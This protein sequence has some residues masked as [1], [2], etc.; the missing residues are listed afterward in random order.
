MQEVIAQILKETL[1]AATAAGELPAVEVEP[2]VT[3]P[4]DKAHG[5]FA[6]NVAMVAAK[7]AGKPPRE[8]ATALAAR[9]GANPMF[10]K[11]EIAGPGFINFYV[12]PAYWPR[13]LK[14]LALLGDDLTKV[15]PEKP[16]KMMVEFVSANP[17]GPL[18]VGHGRGAAVGDSL[19]RLLRAAGHHVDAE[20]YIND[21]GNQMATLGRSTWVRYQQL[22]GR[23]V[24]MPENHYMGDY[25]KEIA[26][27]L[28]KERGKSL[29]DMPESEALAICEAFAGK[30]IL[31]GIRDDLLQFGVSFDRWYSEKALVDSGRVDQEIENLKKAG[32]IVER[33]GALWFRTIDLVGDDKDRV[34]VRNNGVKTYY[35]SDIAYH[36]E[37]YERGYDV[38]VNIWGS[39]HHGYMPRVRAV[40][41]AAGVAQDRLQILLV[42]F[43]N[44]LRDGKQISMSTRSGE[45][46][47]LKAVVDEVGKDAA[48]FFFLLR[49]SD[50]HLDFDLELAKKQSNE[51]PVYY[52]QYAHARICSVFRMAG[53]KGVAE[54]GAA[55]VDFSLLQAPEEISLMK[56]VQEYPRMI[57]IAAADYAPHRV[58]FYLLEL[59][60]RFHKFYNT[61]RIVDETNVPLSQARMALCRTVQRVVR[62][63]L[64]V[65]A[66]SAPESM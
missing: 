24:E 56:A 19:V 42:Q 38:C 17:T 49:K 35:A 41:Q 29:L 63:A 32:W 22:Q 13:E 53:E 21:A 58:S 60:A 3:V 15:T 36:L 50:A 43:V 46:E 66:V 62:A 10:A 11:V 61:H 39:D 52:V 1:E 44:L 59:A 48:R 5:D 65:Y 47:T 64:S 8:I 12:D 37:K 55:A 14:R 26:A 20:Y 33:D 31:D 34:V 23:N 54:A 7:A 25:M 2:A 40:L 9:L 16:L 57:S 51:N 4:K 18:H 45:F 6:S 30:S 27:D 28:A